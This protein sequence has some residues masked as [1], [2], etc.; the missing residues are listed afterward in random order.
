MFEKI[1]LYIFFYNSVSIYRTMFNRKILKRVLL[2][3]SI[4]IILIYLSI[5]KQTKN[6]ANNKR[7]LQI[8]N[9]ELVAK[10][11]LAIWSLFSK[12]KD[13]HATVK[14]L[15]SIKINTK[16]T[17]FDAIILELKE[18]TVPN[19]L[20]KEILHAGWKI[21]QV[22]GIISKQEE[23]TGFTK[24]LLWNV[25]EYKVNYYFDSNVL[26]VRNVDEFLKIHT[27]FQP[28]LHKIGCT[29]DFKD[30]KLQSDFNLNVFVLKPDEQE[31][32]RLMKLKD[33]SKFIYEKSQGEQG[34]LNAVYKNLWYDVGFENNANLAVYTEKKDYWNSKVNHINI[35]YYKSSNFIFC[36]DQ[37]RVLCDLW[38]SLNVYKNI[39]IND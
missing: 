3:F 4:A 23:N 18:S 1:I 29:A 38:K 35:V 31:F 17:K 11:E 30:S 8:C 37:F 9:N 27:N 21:C 39:L 33:D 6:V 12:N 5:I 19:L 25:T 22:N 2:F 15:Q 16:S 10:N 20:R 7:T 34:F 28:S 26:A 32:S 24:L 36:S 13:Y 14:L